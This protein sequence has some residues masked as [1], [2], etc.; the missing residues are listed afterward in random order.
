[1]SKDLLRRTSRASQP[2]AI[3]Y[4]TLEVGQF[5]FHNSG[6]EWECFFDAES[7]IVVEI[8]LNRKL[9]LCEKM[10]C[11]TIEFG[12]G[13]C[14]IASLCSDEGL[15]VQICIYISSCIEFV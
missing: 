10:I 13:P 2:G 15:S 14:A 1:M 11:F 5:G 8:I 12:S 3:G 6:K 4:T 7:G 9:L